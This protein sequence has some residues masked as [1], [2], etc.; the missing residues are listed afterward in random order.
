MKIDNIKKL[1]HKVEKA[2]TNIA[3]LLSLQSKHEQNKAH[4]KQNAA[5]KFYVY[6][7]RTEC[8]AFSV[9]DELMYEAIKAMTNRAIELNA[10]DK[11][12]LEAIELMVNP[13]I[14]E[15]PRFNTQ[16][17]PMPMPPTVPMA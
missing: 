9:D 1:I 2:E 12:V 17:S 8:A 15:K 4:N 3:D 10:K 5:I 11:Q 16:P 7:T 13:E 14:T 6:G